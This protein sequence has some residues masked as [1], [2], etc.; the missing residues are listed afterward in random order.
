M[1]SD[2]ALRSEL[3]RL[4]GKGYKAYKHIKG[5]YAV[6]DFTL[7]IDYVQ[8]DPYA[9]PSQVRVEVAMAVAGFPDWTRSNAVRRIALAD[10]LARAFH[11]V[12]G[13]RGEPDRGSGKSGL[14]TIEAPAQE[15][16]ERTA[17]IIHDDRIEVR[18]RVGLPA[19]G[20]RILGRQAAELLLD[21]V[22]AIVD[23]SLRF[24][25]V[26]AEALRAHVESV[27]DQRALRA[28]LKSLG[29]VA[30]V[31]DA[32]RLP[33]RSGVDP[34]PLEGRVIPFE[35]AVSL[36]VEVELPN[37]GVVRGMGVP[38]GVSLIVGGGYHGKSTV[39]SAIELGIYDHVPGDGRELVA[40]RPDA[41]KI[42]AED[43]RR[44]EGVDIRPFITNLPFGTD[45][46]R[47]SSDDAS[48]STSQAASLVEALEVGAGVL[49][50]DEDTSAT[51]F[52]IRDH[53]MQ[54]LVA[55]DKEPITPFIE[56]VRQLYEEKDVSSIVV[57]GGAGDYFDVADTV[58]MMDEYRPR[59]VTD[60][61][62]RIAARDGQLRRLEA[63]G[64]FAAD[65]SRFPLPGSIDPSRGRR[66]IKI[67]VNGCAT[68]RFGTWDIDLAALE[69]LVETSQA[70]A[71]GRALLLLKE[72]YLDGGV[73]L[74]AALERLER[75]VDRE[76]LDLLAHGRDGRLARVR[77][78][79]VAAALNRLRS[80]RV[81]A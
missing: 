79:E 13:K 3:H 66:P 50:M 61:A 31:G 41:V 70:R 12:I 35:S 72:R 63:G 30:F 6:G 73:T 55:K 14:I 19:R 38:E 64:A 59:D 52:M 54:A 62:K 20:R 74:A 2:A 16:L 48:G 4:D 29:L 56:R 47:F 15:V 24:A 5:A 75:D 43:G 51:N 39:L 26:D 53:R 76:G 23:A 69:Q 7:F 36:A 81:E 25:S 18:F 65:T 17:A 9:A 40:A 80:L 46:T 57:V 71:I 33:R 78:F 60:E 77:R 68:I 1:K 44:V 34:R 67:D 37:R 10:F 42:R 11:V 58:I 28:A 8:G 49:L 32:S 27:E 21:D 45:T 22:P